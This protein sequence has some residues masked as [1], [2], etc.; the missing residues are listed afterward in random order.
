MIQP[1]IEKELCRDASSV[2]SIMDRKKL[3]FISKEALK[4]TNAVKRYISTNTARNKKNTHQAHTGAQ[5]TN[6]AAVK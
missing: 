3:F 1:F 5:S 2:E 4:K 6:M